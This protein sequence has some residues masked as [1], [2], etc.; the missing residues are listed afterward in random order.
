MST[1]QKTRKPVK[2]ATGKC[3]WIRRPDGYNAGIL[4]I[5]GSSY[6]VEQ[7]LDSNIDHAGYRLTNQLKAKVY[8]IDTTQAPW[9]CDCP[10]YEYNRAAATDAETRECKHCRGL[11]AALKAIGQ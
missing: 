10:D 1:L 2:P 6:T 7:L 11:R 5:N 4:E 9:V 3:K 8:D